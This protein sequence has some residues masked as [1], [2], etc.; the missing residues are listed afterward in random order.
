MAASVVSWQQ[1]VLKKLWV[2]LLTHI[3]G[4]IESHDLQDNITK[5]K[6]G[7]FQHLQS[8][9]TDPVKCQESICLR[10]AV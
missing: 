9:Q 8:A 3:R 2:V 5:N 10:Q 6:G 1:T 4:R 7:W